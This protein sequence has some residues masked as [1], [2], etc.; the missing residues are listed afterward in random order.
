MTTSDTVAPRAG[1]DRT[2]R[3]AY[4]LNAAVAWLGVVLTVLLSGLG[5][6]RPAPLE[7]GL[8]GDTPLGAAGAVPRLVD[9]LSYFTI[10]SNIAVAVSVTLL[11]LDPVRDTVARRVLRLSS[12]LMITVTAI[13][14]QVV[15]AP[16]IDVAGWSLLTDP[17][18]HALT[19]LVTVVVWAAWGPRG[20]VTARLVPGALAVPFLWIVWMLAR[21]AMVDAYPYGFANVAE[22][23]YAVVARNLVLVLLFALAL[24]AA[25]WRLDVVLRRRRSLAPAG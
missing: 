1:T 14:Y 17:I 4:A 19:P 23:G 20:W 10:W 22:L 3:R 12:L 7:P 21:G 15:L 5:W 24:A 8:Y 6:Y 13:V 11:A 9:T 2:A 16:A 25:F 18:L